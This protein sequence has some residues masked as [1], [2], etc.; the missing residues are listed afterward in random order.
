MSWLKAYAVAITSLLTGAAVV[1][2]IYK[3]DLTLPISDDHP[4]KEHGSGQADSI[5]SGG[6]N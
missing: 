3:P 5:A 6:S 4:A 2:N 1:H